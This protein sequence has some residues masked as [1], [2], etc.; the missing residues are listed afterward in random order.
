M[1]QF[2]FHFSMGGMF[3]L[4]ALLC[5]A[6]S[7][8]AAATPLVA[9]AAH[10]LNLLLLSLAVVGA[11]CRRGGARV[12]L[13]G[14]GGRRLG[15][16]FCGRRLARAAGAAGLSAISKLFRDAA[17]AR[18]SAA[19][20]HFKAARLDRIEAHRPAAG[21]HACH[22]T[23]VRRRLLAGTN[24]RRQRNRLPHHLGR[25]Q[26]ADL[27]HAAANRFAGNAV[28]SSRP[29][30]LRR[31]PRATGRLGDGLRVSRGRGEK[32]IAITKFGADSG[33]GL[34]GHMPQNRATPQSLRDE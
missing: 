19:A 5:L 3:G 8:L 34:S 23:M 26:H 12:L 10:S 20:T 16:L 11:I 15:L 14:G 1:N 6:C 24:H 30:G 31:A 17:F 29:R 27:G 13:G 22:G 2:R 18:R 33:S 4:V 21:R 9:S 32:M 7:A 25:R 28:L